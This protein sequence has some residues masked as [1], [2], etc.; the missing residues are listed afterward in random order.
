MPKLHD[1]EQR[2][3]HRFI[4]AYGPFVGPRSHIVE[5]LRA[6]FVGDPVDPAKRNAFYEQLRRLEEKGWIRVERDGRAITTIA[7]L[8]APPTVAE[9]AVV[10]RLRSQARRFGYD[11]VPMDGSR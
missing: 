9:A 11:L 10:A 7:A 5:G 8:E 2:R 6:A 3:L 1:T 4:A